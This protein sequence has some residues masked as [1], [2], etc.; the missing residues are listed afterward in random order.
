MAFGD[1]PRNRDAPREF[2]T[3]TCADCGKECEVPFRPTQGRPIYCR[4]CYRR[5]RPEKKKYN[6][7]RF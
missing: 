4:D 6:K 1:R 7:P 3:A 5:N 2:F